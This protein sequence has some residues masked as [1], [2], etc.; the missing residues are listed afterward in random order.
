V[1]VYGVN[2]CGEGN[3]SEELEISVGA[4]NP[5]ISG[6]DVVCDWSDEYYE[7]AENEGSTYTWIV[8]GGTITEGQG[9]YMIT[10]AW[11]GEG[12][13]TVAVEEETVDG[14]TGQSETFEVLVDDCT[15][16]NEG[17]LISDIKVYPNPASHTISVSS[18]II[19]GEDVT[20]YIFNTMGQAMYNS[21]FSA[22]GSKQIQNIDINNLPKGLYIVSLTTKQG[23]VWRGKFEKTR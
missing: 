13:G 12:S 16:I 9:T 1:S 15:D 14:C 17:A 8:T 4:P 20:I 23:K 21:Q 19:M 10:V 3:S 18:N 7:V 6:A 22:T 5:Q 11:S 2:E